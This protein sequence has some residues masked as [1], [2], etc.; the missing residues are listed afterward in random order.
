MLNISCGW[1]RALLISIAAITVVN[2]KQV[3]AQDSVRAYVADVA[4]Q[5]VVAKRQDT[6]LRAG[7]ELYAGDSIVPLARS[8]GQRIQI[9]VLARGAMTSDCGDIRKLCKGLAVP[10][11]PPA[12]SWVDRALSLAMTH[13]HSHEPAQ[14]ESLMSRGAAPVMADAVVRAHG[15]SV[16][17]APSLA[18]VQR[19]QY[20]VCLVPVELTDTAST[21]DAL[22]C[23]ARLRYDWDPRR[24]A[25]LKAAQPIAGLY[26]LRL[27]QGSQRSAAWLLIAT[28]TAFVSLH[29]SFARFNTATAR[30]QRQL[31]PEALQ[32]VRRAYL[33][34]LAPTAT[35]SATTSSR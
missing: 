32:R 3:R 20:R 35:R 5:W 17:I 11:A 16:D 9:I 1:I 14:Y 13:L 25:A 18:A 30:W 22:R 21:V 23:E 12:S 26:E 33:A 8:S 7:A 31:A 15:D 2:A 34:G 29:R 24:P 27:W 4:G 28:D 10:D 19:G 6:P